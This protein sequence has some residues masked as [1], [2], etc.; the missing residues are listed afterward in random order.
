MRIESGGEVMGTGSVIESWRSDPEFRRFWA[1]SL[2]RSLL[3]PTAGKCHPYV[4]PILVGHLNPCSSKAQVSGGV[5]AE[6]PAHTN[7][8]AMVG[9]WASCRVTPR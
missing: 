6:G 4:V 3:K 5:Y 9:R 8:S 7:R 1:S 2:C